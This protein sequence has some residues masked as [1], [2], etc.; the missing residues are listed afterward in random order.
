[1]ATMVDEE[2][3]RRTPAELWEQLDEFLALKLSDNP[4]RKMGLGV[5]LNAERRMLIT[6]LLE[7]VEVTWEQPETRQYW[8]DLYAVYTKIDEAL[9]VP[10]ED[11]LRTYGA[12]VIFR[13]EE[14]NEQSSPGLGP[15]PEPTWYDPDPT[16]G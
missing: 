10:N 5:G 3:S 1:M 2:I 8:F 9:R 15:P 4:L 16:G 11:E 7:A 6:R 12:K 13:G 14:L